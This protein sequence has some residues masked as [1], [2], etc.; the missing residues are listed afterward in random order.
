MQHKQQF[1]S[2]TKTC[3]SNAKLVANSC[4]IISR[5]QCQRE[6]RDPNSQWI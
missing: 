3:S 1:V 6:N 4:S 2:Q 5:T